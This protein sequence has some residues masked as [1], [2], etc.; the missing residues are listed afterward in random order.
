MEGVYFA[1]CRPMHA[2]R[3]GQGS[4]FDPDACQPSQ[5]HSREKLAAG[6]TSGTSRSGGANPGPGTPVSGLV[7][8]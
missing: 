8:T 2:L 1:I 5:W 7:E 4:P 3:R 6:R